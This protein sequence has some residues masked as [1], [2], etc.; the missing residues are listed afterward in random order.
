MLFTEANNKYTLI[1]LIFETGSSGRTSRETRAAFLSS[2]A[3][4]TIFPASQL[5]VF[6]ATNQTDYLRHNGDQ[7]SLSF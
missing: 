3:H 1:F 6:F 7:T 4:L 5:T 2:R